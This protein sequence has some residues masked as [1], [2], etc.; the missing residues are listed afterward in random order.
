MRPDDPGF[1]RALDAWITRCPADEPCAPCACC[2]I[3]S[4][5]LDA[6]GLCPSCVEPDEDD[7]AEL[8][9]GSP[10]ADRD[11]VIA[12]VDRFEATRAQRIT[13]GGAA[14]RPLAWTHCG[15]GRLVFY[16][17]LDTT[18]RC[19]ACPP[20]DALPYACPIEVRR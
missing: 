4:T 13:L 18:G 17:S 15:C 9:A 11:A 5:D 3:E 20:L 19:P 6:H 8:L 7:R 12:P 10:E 1:A 2:R 14:V 16:L